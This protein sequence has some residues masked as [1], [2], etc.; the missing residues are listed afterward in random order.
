MWT[1]VAGGGSDAGLPVHLG[2]VAA[3]RG[4]KPSGQGCAAGCWLR[5]PPRCMSAFGASVAP[6]A[7][8]CKR[9]VCQ[10]GI[11]P[12]EG[13]ASKFEPSARASPDPCWLRWVGGIRGCSTGDRP[14]ALHVDGSKAGDRFDHLPPGVCARKVGILTQNPFL[15]TLLL[16]LELMSGI[17]AAANGA[18]GT[19][20]HPTPSRARS[21]PA[22]L[23][24][25][26]RSSGLLFRP[27]CGSSTELAPW[28]TQCDA[29]L[30]YPRNVV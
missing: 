29:V 1:V 26:F 2:R 9:S 3:G 27:R 30:V 7:R 12:S 13:E 23:L 16:A 8:R 25:T 6:R 10:R 17:S 14:R 5:L 11:W 19:D 21:I 24:A 4:R 15:L 18:V 22:M 20:A 28:M